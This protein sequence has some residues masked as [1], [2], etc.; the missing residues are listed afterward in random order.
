MEVDSGRLRSLLAAAPCKIILLLILQ[1]RRLRQLRHRLRSTWLL[2]L[3]LLRA[4]STRS[5][6]LVPRSTASDPPSASAPRRRNRSVR[7]G[8]RESGGVVQREVLLCRHGALESRADGDAALSAALVADGFGGELSVERVGVLFDWGEGGLRCSS[9]R[10][11]SV[12]AVAFILAA[13]S[14]ARL[15]LFAGA[16]RR[17]L[18]LGFWR[19][20]FD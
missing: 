15:I 2:L 19:C 5:R 13:V 17:C 1:H 4:R 7:V 12:V 16:R 20:A 8:T 10:T 18:G 11:D 9:P 14:A 6:R 3:L